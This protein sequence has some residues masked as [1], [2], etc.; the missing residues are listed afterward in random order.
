MKKQGSIL[1]EVM[2]SIMI[3]S[4]TTTFVVSACIQ[5]NNIAKKRILHEEVERSVCN[6]MK[7]FKFNVTKKDILSML[8]NGEVGFKY[9]KDFSE[10]L[11]EVPIKELEKGSDIE[12]SKLQDDKFG[13]KLK[14]KAEIKRNDNDVLIEKEFTKSWWMDEV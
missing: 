2:A 6:L 14:I 10:K 4:L 8:D 12:V 9:D 13:L 11:I 5:S 3:L 7:E 1:I